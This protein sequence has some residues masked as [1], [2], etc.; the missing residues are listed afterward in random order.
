MI[1]A[2]VL[3]S[4][5]PVVAVYDDCLPEAQR[6]EV[7][8]FLQRT[9]WYFGATS[10]L[11]GK[12]YNYWYKH[13]AGVFQGR[14]HPGEKLTDCSIQLDNHAPIIGDMWKLLQ[15]QLFPDHI[16]ARC[17]AN[18][19]SFGSEGTVHVDSDSADSLT[20]IFYPNRIWDINW[21]GETILF[22]RQP[23]E[24]LATVWPRPNRLIVFPGTIP[25]VARGISRSC[26][27]LRI[28]LMFKM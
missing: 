7:D 23:P 19:H 18:G 8:H 13:F 2:R 5:E 17:Y 10:D 15:A 14:L 11:T 26:P 24:I 25:H 6:A 16:L 27:L 4:Q 12:S 3:L 1:P 21:A 22:H 28:T 20:A 9:P